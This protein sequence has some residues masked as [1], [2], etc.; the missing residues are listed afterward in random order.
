MAWAPQKAGSQAATQGR[1][2]RKEGRRTREAGR[3]STHAWHNPHSLHNQRA[4]LA[5]HTSRAPE[6][7]PVHVVLVMVWH[8]VV[9]H[10]HQ[11][12]HI[13][14]ARSHCSRLQQVG[15]RAGQRRVLSRGWWHACV[16]GGRGLLPA[17]RAAGAAVPAGMP[18]MISGCSRSRSGTAAAPPPT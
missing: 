14:P 18:S 1:Q 8:I 12:L 6:S 11:I 2:A 4:A 7:S 3:R 5:R 10:Q 15:G 9:E 13:Q 16:V 17:Q